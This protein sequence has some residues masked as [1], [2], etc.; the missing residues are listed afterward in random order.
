MPSIAEVCRAASAVKRR[1]G[2]VLNGIAV[3]C[4]M[5]FLVLTVIEAGTWKQSIQFTGPFVEDGYART[6]DLQVPLP[7]LFYLKGDSTKDPRRSELQLSDQSGP[8]GPAHSS[9]EDIRALGDGR[10]QYWKNQLIFSARGNLPVQPG[11][12]WTATAPI[13]P[14]PWLASLINWLAA[15]GAVWFIAGQFHRITALPAVQWLVRNKDA[16]AART[17]AIVAMLFLAAAI[18]GVIT[19]F[20]VIRVTER[21][22]FATAGAS[23]AGEYGYIVKRPILYRPFI[24]VAPIESQAM[25][26][27]IDGVD[28]PCIDS[29]KDVVTLGG[30]KCNYQN[31]YLRISAPDNAPVASDGRVYEARFP[32]RVTRD[33]INLLFACGILFGAA[34]RIGASAYRWVKFVGIVFLLVGAFLLA[35]NLTGLTRSLRHPDL[36]TFSKPG[37]PVTLTYKDAKA[38]LAWKPGDTAETYTTR[39]TMTIHQSVLRDYLGRDF[40]EFHVYIPLWENWILHFLGQLDPEV[41]SY[42]FASGAR[43]VNRGV[44]LCG[45]VSSAL[46]WYL[47]KHGV[48]ANVVGLTGH[49]VVT[50]E[51]APGRWEIFDPDNGIVIPYDLATLENNASLVRQYYRPPVAELGLDPDTGMGKALVDL[52]VDFYTSAENNYIT[53]FD[54]HSSQLVGEKRMYRLK[55]IIPFLLIGAGVVVAIGARMMRRYLSRDGHVLAS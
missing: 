14:R 44:G 53:E 40:K 4:L 55:W 9:A 27:R 45:D 6:I 23:P 37:D 48:R 21:I 41:R 31:D 30:G 36:M 19:R 7:K 39:A 42:S 33:A 18:I 1:Y 43:E 49:V 26:I 50:A 35:A 10:Y 51:V 32:I 38:L 29:V 12:T 2:T 47:R 28:Y 3:I 54:P 16:V 52:Y 20:D 34:A 24:K 5:A 15:I 11:D 25:V 8:L 13:Y 22:D 46:V 17:S